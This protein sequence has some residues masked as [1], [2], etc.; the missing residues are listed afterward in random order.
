MCASRGRASQIKKIGNKD[1]N[2]EE[3]LKVKLDVE[4]RE[5]SNLNS[6]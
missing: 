1:P 2:E 3:T 4:K 5:G 6:R